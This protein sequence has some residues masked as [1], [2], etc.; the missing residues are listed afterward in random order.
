[1]NTVVAGLTIRTDDFYC[2][3]LS[4]DGWPRAWLVTSTFLPK[5]VY[6]ATLPKD[7]VEETD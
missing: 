5:K 7:D 6:E 1:M 2:K 3:L 4:R